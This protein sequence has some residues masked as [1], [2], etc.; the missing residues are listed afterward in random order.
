[1]AQTSFFAD[2]LAVVYKTV[3]GTPQTLTVG[4]LKGV[5]IRAEWDHVELYG[6]ESVFREDIA[7]TNVRVTVNAKTSKFHPEM[8]GLILGTENADEDI[9]GGVDAG[10]TMAEI[11]DTNTC[12]LFDIWGT[13]TGKNSEDYNV[14][15][16]N[17]SWEGAPW[18]APEGEYMMNDLTG[19]GDKMYVGYVTV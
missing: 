10:N 12:P 18:A 9:D 15:V 19:V 16:T 13:V 2:T 8:I 14:K 7:R 5:E 1:M 3:E 4:V 17:I 11:T 6:Q